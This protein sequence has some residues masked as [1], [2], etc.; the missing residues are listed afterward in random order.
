MGLDNYT[1]VVFGWKVE[2]EE[3]NNLENDLENWDED[4]YDKVQ[5][6]MIEDTMCGNY[7]Y[8]GIILCSYDAVYDPEEVIINDDLMIVQSKIWK[9]F[10]KDNPEF[11]KLI[12]K[13]QHGEPKLYVFQNIW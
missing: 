3:V 11:E 8:F 13:Y 1:K 12:E 6:I 10:L 9:D 2:G 5:D 4:Y 7:I